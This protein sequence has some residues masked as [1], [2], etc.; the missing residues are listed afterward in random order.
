MRPR[1][2]SLVRL[3]VEPLL[4]AILLAVAVRALVRIYA[5]PSASMSPTLL[6]GDRM[7]VTRYVTDHPARGDVVVF[8]Q[9]GRT[10]VTVKRVIG[11]PGDFVEASDGVV[12]IGGKVLDEPY[13]RPPTSDISPQIVPADHLFVLGDNRGDS[14]DSRSWGPLPA[15]LIIGR[16]RLVLWRAGGSGR[17]FQRIE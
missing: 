16:A 6:E 3:V 17:V 15:R 8:E 12:R 7:V 4:L 5:V 2:K 14:V 1:G 10:S 11:L 9:P 13:A